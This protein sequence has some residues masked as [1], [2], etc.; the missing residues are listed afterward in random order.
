MTVNDVNTGIPPDA[1]NGIFDM[2]VHVNANSSRRARN[3]LA[4]GLWLTK[5]LVELPA[6]RSKQEPRV[7]AEEANSSCTC[8][9]QSANRGGAV[10]SGILA[11]AL[12]CCWRRR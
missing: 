11:A 1:L 5:R 9:L 3:P 7:T 6:E 10:P 12:E 2:F 8:P 4:L